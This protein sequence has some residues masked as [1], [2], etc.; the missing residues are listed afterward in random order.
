MDISTRAEASRAIGAVRTRRA[1]ALQ[2]A[3]QNEAAHGMRA[4]QP[5]GS[6]TMSNPVLVELTRGGAV[7][8][9]HTGAIAIVRPNGD[10]VAS[11]GDIDMPVFPRSAVKAFQ[12]L[13][14]VESGAADALAY[15][16]ADLALACASHSGTPRHT[17]RAGSMLTRA[18]LTVADMAC[19]AHAP[20]ADAQ[21]RALAQ[22]G[23][24]PSALHNN[25]S[26][27][28]AGMLGTCAH[29][30]DATAGYLDPRHPHQQRIMRVFADFCGDAFDA[31]RYGIDG[32]SA[33]NWSISLRATAKA[34]AMFGTGDG[35]ASQRK[36]AASRLTAAC[37]AEPDMVA[38]PERLDTALM[39][40]GR[41]RVFSKTGAEGVFC[42]F[43]PDHGLGLAL[44]IDDGAK[45]AS[46]AVMV[47]VAQRLLPGLEAFG[48]LGPITNW[49]GIE[50]GA[51]RLADAA[52]RSLD[53]IA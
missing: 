49:R 18:K 33:P 5:I 20:M 14:I 1:R 2:H 34:F 37:M 42:A 12:A 28:H 7:E 9:R 26:G 32:C 19:G 21:A 39:T 44:K 24:T 46:E 51:I 53:Q 8:C 27:K 47:G 16:A 52:R 50:T 6:L 30:G 40:A 38:G 41:G 31:R 43:F 10:V 22:S 45:R 3:L 36:A 23:G 11:A 13:P 35:L 4:P 29:C 17:E 25:C 15:T 48:C